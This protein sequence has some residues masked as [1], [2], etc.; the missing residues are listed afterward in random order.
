MRRVVLTN[1]K[2][3]ARLRAGGLA[4]VNARAPRMRVGIQGN[5]HRFRVRRVS[6]AGAR[7]RTCTLAGGFLQ[8]RP[9]A[10]EMSAFRYARLLFA[11]FAFAYVHAVRCAGGGGLYLP[12][13]KGVFVGRA[14]SRCCRQRGKRQ[15]GGK[16]KFH[17]ILHR[18][19]SLFLNTEGLWGV[20]QSPP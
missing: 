20:P 7:F 9:V 13:A 14:A 6:F 8:V 1:E 17:K 16:R 5:F 11:T 4:F 18:I 19:L 12:F 15:K 2:L 3:F 10:P